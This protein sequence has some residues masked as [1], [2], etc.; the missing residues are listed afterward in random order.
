MK[1]VESPHDPRAPDPGP[2][3]LDLSKKLEHGPVF[4]TAPRFDWQSALSPEELEAQQ[5]HRE[6]NSNKTYATNRVSEDYTTICFAQR[7]FRS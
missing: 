3:F 2:G 6:S 5:R 4:G 1:R 7:L